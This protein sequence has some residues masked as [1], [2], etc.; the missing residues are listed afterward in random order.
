MWKMVWLEQHGTGKLDKEEQ[1]LKD[2]VQ[3]HVTELK[4][5][6]EL[7]GSKEIIRKSLPDKL[8]FAAGNI[9]FVKQTLRKY[10]K[11]LPT[12]NDYPDYLKQYLHRDI[13]KTTMGKLDESTLPRFI[14]PVKVLKLFS[15]YIA[16][17][18]S[19]LY[20]DAFSPKVEIYSAAVVSITDECRVY[21][22]NDTFYCSDGSKELI[23]IIKDIMTLL[24]VR[25][26]TVGSFDMGL[27]NGQ[28]G[29][30]EVNEGF[31]LGAYENVPPYLY[32][33]IISTRFQQL[34]KG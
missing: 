13:I 25:G 14:K 1:I 2:Y 10:K 6:V 17:S 4:L 23:P 24:R 15:G 30:V 31:S 27:I 34:I 20:F 19:N 28:W 8:A 3:A 29:L 11:D 33:A 16:H 22:K 21:Y 5:I 26:Y 7:V 32:Y 9:D 18:T 12:P